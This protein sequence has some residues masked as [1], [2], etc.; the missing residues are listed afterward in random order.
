MAYHHGMRRRVLGIALVALA[1]P[2]ALLPVVIAEGS[3]HIA[4]RPAAHASAADFLARGPEVTWRDVRIAAQDG[5]ML[6]AWFFSPADANGGAV[7]L[8]H[9]VGD[10]RLGMTGHADYLLRAG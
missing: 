1:L 7:L 4:N 3:L 10:T 5:V 8:L 6:D 9:G 2:I